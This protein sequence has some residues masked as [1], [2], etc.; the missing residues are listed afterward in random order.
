MQALQ[1]K[2]KELLESGKVAVIIG[3]GNGSGDGVRP[4]FIR[5][6][7]NVTKLVF[8]ARCRQNLAVYLS[9]PEIRKMGRPAIVAIPSVVKTI[10]Q[11]ISENQSAKQ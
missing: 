11:L 5:N 2:A 3:Y 8:D 10:V 7:A 4:V 6:T 9:K 1:Q